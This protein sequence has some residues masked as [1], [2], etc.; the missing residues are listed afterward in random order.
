MGY[1]RTFMSSIFPLKRLL[2]IF[3]LT[4]LVQ[5]SVSAKSKNYD[6]IA[7]LKKLEG[8]I[9]IINENSQKGTYGR[10][11]ILLFNGNKIVTSK[12]SKT[13]ILFRDGSRIRL[14]QNSKLILNF[15]EEKFINKRSF[16]Y[17]LSLKEGSIRGRFGKGVQTAKILTPTA[18]IRSKGTS[19]RISEKNN[20]S[21]IS[22]TEG[23]LEVSNLSGKVTIT[24]G[25]WL[26]KFGPYS[27]LS[28]FIAPITNI[29]SLKTKNFEIDFQDGESKQVELSIQIQNTVNEKT[30]KSTGYVIFESN[31]KK[32]NLPKRILLN[33]RGFAKMLLKIHPPSLNDKEFIGM[34]K[35]RA[36]LDSD[37]HDDVG[38]G[39]LI[40]KIKNFGKK[41]NILLHPDRGIIEKD[42][43]FLYPR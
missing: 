8:T 15:S 20:Y 10:E 26:N 27:N 17:H 2:I 25:Q 42:H 30:I 4:Y 13:S 7:T 33:E 12:N 28:K 9:K 6:A 14:F 35:I 18:I 19:F 37:Q 1:W 21:T 40:L 24:S 23:N 36:Y 31:Y 39:L 22:L 41:R 11:G 5:S 43:V 16:N 29:L 34:I 38:D 32:I 3:I